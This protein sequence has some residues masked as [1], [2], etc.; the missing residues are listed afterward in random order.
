MTTV[1]TKVRK[2]GKSQM[3]N[4]S[5]AGCGKIVG[6]ERIAEA[7]NSESIA[8]AMQFISRYGLPAEKGPGAVWQMSVDKFQAWADSLGWK[9]EMPESELRN[10]IHKINLR[11]AGPGQEIKGSITYLEKRLSRHMTTLR[12]LMRDYGEACPIKKLPDG[13]YQVFQNE[14]DLFLMETTPARRSKWGAESL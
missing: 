4:S 11:E 3:T 8:T 5:G 2:T 9:P 7:I 1:K 12:D 13:Q 10:R 6:I 14:W